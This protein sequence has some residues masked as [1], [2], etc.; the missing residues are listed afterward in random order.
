LT[1]ES[2]FQYFESHQNA[3]LIG[4]QS[5]RIRGL[6]TYGLTMKELRDLAKSIGIDHELATEL[7]T[8]NTYDAMMLATL[9]A[10]PHLCS[11]SLLQSWA[12]Y[13]SST[14][15]VDQGLSPLMMNSIY[16]HEIVSTWTLHPHEDIRY[17]GYS[18]LS[19]YFRMEKLE[20]LD[21]SLGSALLSKIEQTILQEP[22]T[23]QNA[24]N[25][26]VVMAGLHVPALFEQAKHT[27]EV[28][29]YI[30]P[31]VAKNSCNIQSALDYIV[32]YIDQPQYSRTAKLRKESS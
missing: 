29:G 13:A 21:I 1:K 32:R 11:P 20:L 10:S 19:T 31:L 23:I 27:A 12:L 25:N 8:T 7:F 6:A 18:F 14:S 9:I 5:K 28:I 24:M 17:A 16:R 4:S 15:V 26:A 3:S 2:V 22:S 30:M